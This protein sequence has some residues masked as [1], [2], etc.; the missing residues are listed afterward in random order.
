VEGGGR[1]RI[2]STFKGS[3]LISCIDTINLRSRPDSTQKHIREDSNVCDN[4]DNIGKWPANVFG[5]LDDA[6]NAPIYRLDRVVQC[7]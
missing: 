2:A 6:L 4:N 7:A 5:D 3:T 1:I